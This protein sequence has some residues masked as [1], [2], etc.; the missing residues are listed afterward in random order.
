MTEKKFEI[1]EK[2]FQITTLSDLKEMA[3]MFVKSGIFN[4][5]AGEVDLAKAAIKILAGRELGLP[6][7]QAMRNI[8]LFNGQTSFKYQFIAAKVKQSGRY[9]FSPVEVS[10][11]K[12]SVQ[13]F[14]KGKPVY[15]ST[16]TWD[17]ANRQGLTSKDSWKR[18]PPDMLF[19]RA[20][21]KGVNKV[22]PEVML[23]P[24]YAEGDFG[25]VPI[26]NENA[27][28]ATSVKEVEEPA[29]EV[30]KPPVKKSVSKPEVTP[31]S[32]PD[33]EKPSPATVSQPPIAKTAPIE[34]ESIP[35]EPSSDTID[36]EVKDVA[37][38]SEADM[39]KL[40]ETALTSGWD[41]DQLNGYVLSALAEIGVNTDDEDA[42]M[43][44]FNMDVYAQVFDHVQANKPED[45]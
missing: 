16:F 21:T 30:K 45:A 33:V 34:E 9:D 27:V 31:P 12:A 37:M 1:G 38:P 11:K 25:E 14:D 35:S 26:D 6:P 17:D 4:E 43:S 44:A 28:D 18:N 41:E 23:Q 8:D 2:A 29:A 32:V 36:A 39:E 13:F 42:V 20:L 7:F 22:C 40:Q 10:D 3:A 19:A 15:L 5:K 24:A